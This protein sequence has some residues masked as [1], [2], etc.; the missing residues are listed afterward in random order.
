MNETLI[1]LTALLNGEAVYCGSDTKPASIDVLARLVA[2]GE[3]IEHRRGDR[4]WWQ[5]DQA[6]IADVRQRTKR[7][8]GL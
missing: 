5:I 3:I 6:T 8:S 7:V 4:R 1:C 2:S